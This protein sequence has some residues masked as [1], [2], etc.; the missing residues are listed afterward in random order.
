MKK[1]LN[2]TFLGFGLIGG[3]IGKAIRKYHKDFKISVFDPNADNITAALN[4]NT[5]D[6]KID[7]INDIDYDTDIVFL[8]S[9]IDFNI[10][11]IG[12]L[13]GK[14]SKDTII[15]DVGSVKG[16]T[17]TAAVEAGFNSQFI[18]GHPMTG[19]E[20]TDYI[21]SNATILENA[22][23]ILTP[24]NEVSSE[25][26]ELFKDLI[27]SIKAL[28]IISE[29]NKHDYA[30]AAISHVPHLI[31]S[32]L[33]NMVKD[34]DY[35]DGFMKM[36]AAG[37]FKDITR[38]ASSSPIMWENICK[39]NSDNIHKLLRFYIDS[40]IAIDNNVTNSNSDNIG[41]IFEK[42]REYRNSITDNVKGAI[43]STYKMYLNIN[44]ETG[45]IANIAGLLSSNNINIK[46]IG[47]T[48]NRLSEAGVLYIVFYDKKSFDAAKEVL[49][50]DGREI[51]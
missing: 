32:A 43:D 14:I 2:I 45:A 31:A 22:Y 27:A 6:R 50:K 33:V 9:P 18:G 7:S 4:D 46:N 47:I 40:L 16:T 28:P 13:K 19:S 38:I 35:D 30:T 51:L 21:N 24:A 36:I 49:I 17:H 15:T 34:N 41:N 48:H 11:N 3:S 12:C 23:Y 10:E 26:I 29:C 8:C 42:S 20:K 1:T 25:K 5:I 37:G 44:D 39:H